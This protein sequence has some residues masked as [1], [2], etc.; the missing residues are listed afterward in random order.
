M[1]STGEGFEPSS[2]QDGE[3][4]TTTTSSLVGRRRSI[5]VALAPGPAQRALRFG[6]ALYIVLLVAL[7]LL[8][9][10]HAGLAQGLTLLAAAISEPLARA[11]L[12]LTLWTAALVALVNAL[13][14]TATAWMLVRYRFWGRGALSAIVDLPFAI[15]TLVAGVMLALLYGPDSWL[16]RGLAT[17]GFAV[18]FAR[19]GIVLALM[20]VT[21]P[22]V[23]RAVEPVLLEI[24]PAEEEAALVLGA[25]PFRVFRTVF[26]PAITPA[27]LSGTIRS[28]GRALG[29][30]GSIAVVAGNIPFRTLTAPVYVFAEIERGA[31]RT[32]AAISLLML[33]IA[34]GL[35][36]LAIAIERRVGARHGAV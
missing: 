34:L 33:A 16:G 24:D 20:F 32:A 6:I 4:T 15:P 2:T 19:P 9:L 8:A 36:G 10:A 30:F 27:V 7:P 1:R 28:L 35:H 3:A 5:V 26:L 25:G 18:V 12:W 29:E 13:L 22:F 17:H 11:A 21:L 23:V 14:G 31:P